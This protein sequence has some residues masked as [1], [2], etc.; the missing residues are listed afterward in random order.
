MCPSG[1]QMPFHMN[2]GCDE[3]TYEETGNIQYTSDIAELQY[4]C[5]HDCV[6]ECN[7]QMHTML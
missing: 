2:T 7:V 3:L 6:V 4:T 5:M 1:L